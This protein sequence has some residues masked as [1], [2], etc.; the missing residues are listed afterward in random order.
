MDE[1][2][3]KQI[4]DNEKSLKELELYE[5]SLHRKNIVAELVMG[6]LA[7]IGIIAFIVWAQAH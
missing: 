7:I 1:F 4:E 6:A 5:K 2:L 3:Q